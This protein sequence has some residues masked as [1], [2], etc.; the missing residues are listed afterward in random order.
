SRCHPARAGPLLAPP[1]VT[2]VLI[3]VRHGQ[4]T[5][6]VEGRISG[7]AEVSLTE[8]GRRQAVAVA[9]AV[10][11]PAKVISSPLS[12][13]RLTAEAFGLPVETDERWV[14]LDY[15]ELEGLPVAD[16]PPDAWASKHEEGGFVPPGGEPL[17]ALGQRVRSACEDLVAEAT[18]STVVVVTHV[19]PIK[20]AVAWALGVGD[21][22]AWRLFVA[23]ASVCRIGFGPWGPMLVAFNHHYPP[24]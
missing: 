16:V 17:L 3:L 13:A 11:T 12:R 1:T 22:V 21:E 14:E 9:A 8:L 15:G 19:S 7:R 23:D 24:D 5:A 20:A 18:A 4:T 2:G 10:E 6:N